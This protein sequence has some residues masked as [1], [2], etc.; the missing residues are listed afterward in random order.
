[1]KDVT[2]HPP[3]RLQQEP[4]ALNSPR[5]WALVLLGT[6]LVLLGVAAAVFLLSENSQVFAT[7]ENSTTVTVVPVRVEYPAPDLT[8]NSLDGEKHSLADYLGSVVLVNNW[9]TWCPPCKD[10]MPALQQYYEMHQDQ[11]FVLIAIEAGEPEEDVQKFV[12]EY[13][14]TFP[15]WTDRGLRALNAFKN[16]NL[17]SSYVIDRDGV[18]RLAWTGPISLAMLEKYLTPLLE[19]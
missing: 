4:V 5:I 10:E 19:E 18:I 17:P 16:D 2:S 8:L 1:M 15:V 9:A 11:G 3:S 6:G 12:L 13:G 14:L 7:G